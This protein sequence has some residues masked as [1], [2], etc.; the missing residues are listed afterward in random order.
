MSVNDSSDDA[1]SSVPSAVWR[2]FAED[3]E[4]A[5]RLSAPREPSALER[6]ARLPD[7]GGDDHGPAPADGSVQWVGEGY[8]VPHGQQARRDMSER[9]R[10]R[11]LAQVLLVG[12]VMTAVVLAVPRGASAPDTVD[13]SPGDVVL[14]ETEKAGEGFG[15]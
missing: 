14:H 4:E 6:S 8:D 1:A 10:W 5:I 2:R 3:N 7:G 11:Y 12:I 9:E 13:G 15:V